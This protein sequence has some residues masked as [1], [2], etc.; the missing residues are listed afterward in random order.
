LVLE[1]LGYI[2]CAARDYAG[3]YDWYT[4]AIRKAGN[5]WKPL[6]WRSVVALQLG[7]ASAAVESARELSELDVPA[8]ILEEL[9]TRLETTRRAG[10]WEPTLEG[11]RLAR[12]VR[13]SM[14]EKVSKI[15]DAFHP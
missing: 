6:A 4:K 2:H 10:V 14:P 9:A 1:N 15:C 12:E 7:K 3:S 5:R 8:S 13:E 11:L